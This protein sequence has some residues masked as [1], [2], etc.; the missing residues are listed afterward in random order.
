MSKTTFPPQC[1][2]SCILRFLGC[3]LK[4]QV[5][6]KQGI[7]YL[8][9]HKTCHNS[10]DLPRSPCDVGQLTAGWWEA[11]IQ[12]HVFIA[13]WGC[14]QMVFVKISFRNIFF[15]HFYLFKSWDA[16][17]WCHPPTSSLHLDSVSTNPNFDWYPLWC[18]MQQRILNSNKEKWWFD[19]AQLCKPLQQQRGFTSRVQK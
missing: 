14:T 9:F 12:C 16:Y 4:S 17:I 6:Y 11:G 19:T 2:S 1:K 8:F 10:W 5:F 15:L 7:S 13:L 18:P 3:S